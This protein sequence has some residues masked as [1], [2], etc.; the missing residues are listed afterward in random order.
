MSERYEYLLK[1]RDEVIETIKPKLNAWGIK[2]KNY[3]YEIIENQNGYY[4]EVLR[5]YDTKIGCDCNS[6]FA[7]EMEVLKYLIVVSFCRHC[8]FQFSKQLKNFCMRYW[9]DE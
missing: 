3:D 6:V 2:D 8:G 7:V 1:K 9:K 4:N 5:I